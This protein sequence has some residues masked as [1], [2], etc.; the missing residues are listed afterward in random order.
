MLWVGILE[1]KCYE[2]N[3]GGGGEGLD[4]Y[5][6]NICLILTSSQCLHGMKHLHIILL[7]HS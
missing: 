6:Y 4:Q 7:A 1:Q 3:D 2:E 5:M